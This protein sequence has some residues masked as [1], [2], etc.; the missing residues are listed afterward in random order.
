MT[1]F[2]GP[3]RQ[4]WG[5]LL[6]PPRLALAL[7]P[8]EAAL[9]IPSAGDRAAWAT[10]DEAGTVADAATREEISSRAEAELGQ[11]WPQPLASG[12]ARYFLDG[13]RDSY[14]QAVFA[15]Q[16]RLSRATLVAATTLDPRWIDE[17]A[18]GITLLCEQSS[19]CWPA[20]DDTFTRHGSVLPT[21]TEP[22][23]DLGAGEVAAQ[24][25][26]CDHVLGEPLEDRYPGLRARLRR[27][28]AQRVLDPF[29]HRR[30]WHWLGLDGDVDNWSP[31][32]HGNV[33]V[34]AL[35][36]TH[37]P[38][39]RAAQVADVLEGLDRYV[40]SLPPD[41]AVDEG[42]AYWWN[43][44]GRAIEALDLLR[45]ATDGALDPADIEVLRATVSFPHA[46]HLGGEWHVSYADS[47]ARQTTGQPWAALHRAARLMGDDAA[48]RHAA[49]HRR[50]AAP[51]ADEDGGLGR[52]L[53]AMFDSEWRRTQPAAS[54][55]PR[56]VY[57]P[58]I[59][60]LVAREHE[61]SSAGLTLAVKAGHNGEHHN[62]NDVGSIVV[63]VDGV[64]VVV[65]AGRPTYTGQ[66]FGPDRYRIPTMQ[67]TWHSVPEIRGTPQS[68]GH[69]YAARSVSSRFADAE[70]CLRMDLSGAYERSDVR[71]WWRTAR[72]DRSHAR[73]T[74]TDEWDLVDAA[75]L[76]PTV[77]HVLLHGA[78]DMT[79]GGATIT[80]PCGTHRAALRWSPSSV[81]SDLTTLHLEDPMLTNVW[82]PTLTRLALDIGDASSGSL[83]VSLEVHQ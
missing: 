24:L 14:E 22:F 33:L 37:D 79:D 23:L 32:I 36:L 49:A 70:S 9:P 73:I 83:T 76:H 52:L 12:Y 26:W 31:W 1:R 8:C 47:V 67:S 81:R 72:L 57:L 53:L 13:D 3:L 15:R 25:A 40:A 34:A 4:A 66:T 38:R 77:V 7:R 39:A 71:H 82:G 43:G 62:H 6:D 58:S 68:T 44:A 27:E 50:P 17:V 19:W 48:A 5:S 56:E 30:D 21:V 11:P 61:G 10:A 74:V 2:A 42:H 55:L 75:D 65:D 80:T 60:V 41:G 29:R 69:T 28:V 51:V 45:H 46:M 16:R 35:R 59:G 64:P 78:V 18:D 20:H 63:A 54:P